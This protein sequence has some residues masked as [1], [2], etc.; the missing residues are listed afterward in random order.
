MIVKHVQLLGKEIL[1][2]I[3]SELAASR[4]VKGSKTEIELALCLYSYEPFALN[5]KE[6]GSF[7]Y[8]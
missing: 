3:D 1:E 8:I 2:S 6:A 7:V 5:S 4:F